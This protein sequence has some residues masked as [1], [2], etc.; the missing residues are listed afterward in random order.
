MNATV[1]GLTWHSLVGRRRAVL[2]IVL[3][4]VLILLAV[5]VR[6]V[7]GRSSSSAVDLLGSFSLGFLIPLLCLIAGTGAIGP[8]IDDGSIV[9]LLAKP[10]NR[11]VIAVSKWVV[12]LGVIVLFGVLPTLVAG[13]VLAGTDDN[14]A[15]GYAAGAL[16]AGIAYATVFLLLAVI[17]RNAVVIGLL[18]ALVW[19]AA[20][21]GYVPGAQTLSIQQWALAVTEK[22]LGDQAGPLGIESAVGLGTGVS[23]LIIVTVAGL[24]YTGYRLRSIRISGDE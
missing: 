23:L 15:S 3:P 6:L 2:L 19:E 16:L 20:I 9:Y 24:A 10:L 21:G 11:Y 1:A 18:Y 22:M 8:E 4:T 14:V 12:A 7:S 13:F 5:V 17:T